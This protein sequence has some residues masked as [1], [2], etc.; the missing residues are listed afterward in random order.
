MSHLLKNAKSKSQINDIWIN[1]ARIQSD[2]EA[3]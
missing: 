2:Y 3:Y 1:V